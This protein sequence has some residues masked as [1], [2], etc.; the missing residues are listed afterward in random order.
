ME[1][2]F[3]INAHKRTKYSAKIIAN[4]IHFVHDQYQT[5]KNGVQHQSINQISTKYN[6]S[7]NTKT[8]TIYY[9]H[10]K[11]IEVYTHILIT[12]CTFNYIRSTFSVN[13]ANVMI[14]K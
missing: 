8:D 6:I 5:A 7:T 13:H 12:Q 9:K 4:D 10:D 11:Q 1:H 14:M 2:L 3:P